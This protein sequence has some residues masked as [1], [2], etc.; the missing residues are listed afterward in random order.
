MLTV[1]LRFLFCTTILVGVI[2]PGTMAQTDQGQTSQGR[3]SQGQSADD[4]T[5]GRAVAFPDEF[6]DLDEEP[7]AVTIASFSLPASENVDR[8]RQLYLQGLEAI[9]QE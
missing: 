2:V 4:V 3:A 6:A 5:T 8:A 1:A 9:E 7:E